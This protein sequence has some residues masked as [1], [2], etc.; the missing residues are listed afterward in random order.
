MPLSNLVKVTVDNIHEI[1]PDFINDHDSIISTFEDMM[2]LILLM[3]RKKHLFVMDRDILRE[4]MV[5]F[6]YMCSPDDDIN[7]DRI[8]CLLDPDDSDEDDEEISV[9][10]V[11]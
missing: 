11:D 5:D 1:V 3:I 4:C 2:E 6:T 7:K 10:N 8:I 9:P